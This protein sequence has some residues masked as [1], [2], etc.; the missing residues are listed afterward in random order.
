ML[1]QKAEFG[2]VL[3]YPDQLEVGVDIMLGSINVQQ[4]HQSNST[5][6]NWHLTCKKGQDVTLFRP[7]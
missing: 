5:S 7:V 2:E 6:R 1:K 3:K 4:Q